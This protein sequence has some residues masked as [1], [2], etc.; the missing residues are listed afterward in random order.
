MENSGIPMKVIQSYESVKNDEEVF[1]R[2][3][4]LEQYRIKRDA[5]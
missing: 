3:K 2:L 5:I 4:E 1:E